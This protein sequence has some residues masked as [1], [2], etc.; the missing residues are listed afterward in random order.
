M[1]KLHLICG[2]SLHSP[3]NV[4]HGRLLPVVCCR[5]GICHEIDVAGKCSFLRFWILEKP[6][7]RCTAV[8]VANV[9]K[10]RSVRG[11]SE[12]SRGTT[13]HHSQE[14]RYAVVQCDRYLGYHLS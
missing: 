13:N 3:R 6:S 7:V 4:H 14:P 11:H 12:E 1:R 10:T 9:A 5:L 2:F 8:V